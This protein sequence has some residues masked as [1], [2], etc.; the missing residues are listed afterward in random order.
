MAMVC[1]AEDLRH[2]REVALKVLKPEL[3][4]AEVLREQGVCQIPDLDLNAG[5]VT[6]SYFEWI[7]KLSGV[8]FGRME[9]RS[10]DASLTR[11]LRSVESLT[12]KKFGPSVFEDVAVGAS[13]EDLVNSGLEETM[14]LA[15]QGIRETARK[16]DTDL[17]AAGFIT[18]I[19]KIATAYEKRG[20]FT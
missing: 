17:R 2:E 18:S 20:I 16:Y 8:R 3:A 13:E 4:A 7:K 11:A 15:Y 10:E 19:E 12:E 1:R 6:V 9:R 5:G 14:V